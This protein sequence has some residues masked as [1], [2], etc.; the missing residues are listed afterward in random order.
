[1]HRCD[2]RFVAVSLPGVKRPLGQ[3]G[4]VGVADATSGSAPAASKDD[5]DDDID[6][7][8]S[9]EEVRTL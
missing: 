6:L 4:P 3:Y 7:F 8:G 5:D 2:Q 9:D 1:M